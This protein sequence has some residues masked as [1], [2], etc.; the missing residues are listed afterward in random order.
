MRQMGLD[1]ALRVLERDP[2]MRDVQLDRAMMVRAQT[3]TDTRGR[4]P[5]G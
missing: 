1:D 3:H 5:S 4:M 2:R